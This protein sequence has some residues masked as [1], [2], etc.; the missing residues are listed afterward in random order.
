MSYLGTAQ[1]SG[2]TGYF[3]FRGTTLGADGITTTPVAWANVALATAG[4][5]VKNRLIGFGAISRGLAET[6]GGGRAELIKGGKTEHV[7]QTKIETVGAYVVDTREA[8]SFTGVAGVAFTMAAEEQTIKKGHSIDG[9][10]L[11]AVTTSNLGLQ[12]DEKITLVSGQSE[13]VIDSSGVV[14]K[15]AMKLNIEATS[16]LK[17]AP[18]AIGPA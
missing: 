15:A 4:G 14:I 18:P 1:K 12:A 11:V 3:V 5:M 13:V 8:A 17:S 6:I 9:G 2:H 7:T 16:E 10:D